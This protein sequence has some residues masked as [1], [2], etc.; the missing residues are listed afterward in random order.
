MLSNS[1]ASLGEILR[2]RRHSGPPE[3]R[4][5]LARRT[6]AGAGEHRAEF[7]SVRE[8][9]EQVFE[10]R[11][12]EG[13]IGLGSFQRRVRR[14]TGPSRRWWRR[15]GSSP[16]RTSSPA[17]ILFRRH[18][19]VTDARSGWARRARIGR[20]SRNERRSS[21][22]S[23]AVGVPV[24]GLAGRRLQDDRLQV[25]RDGPVERPRPGRLLLRHASQELAGAQVAERGLEGEQFVERQAQAVDV[26]PVIGLAPERLGGEITQRADDVARIRSGRRAR[27]ASPG[28]S[29]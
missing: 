16:R 9:R 3:R 29:P 1:A 25:Q 20:S 13:H 7:S 8:L 2:Q 19:R 15:T 27:P 5:T 14:R 22:R 17:S 26:A 21:A 18:H 6:G 10:G 23:P 24:A 28:R 12:R 4:S 11:E